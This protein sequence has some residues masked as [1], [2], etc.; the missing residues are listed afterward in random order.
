MEKEKKRCILTKKW[1]LAEPVCDQD[2]ASFFPWNLQVCVCVCNVKRKREF[3]KVSLCV[4]CMFVSVAWTKGVRYP[5]YSKL[6]SISKHFLLMDRNEQFH[7]LS[8]VYS[9]QNRKARY[10]HNSNCWG[11]GLSHEFKSW[12]LGRNNTRVEI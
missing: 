7:K 1:T 2:H 5:T 8:Y 10:I 12:W 6:N 3:H 11:S 4:F 9:M